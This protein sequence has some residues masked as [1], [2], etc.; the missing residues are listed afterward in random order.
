MNM[1]DHSL[2]AHRTMSIELDYLAKFNI[3]SKQTSNIELAALIDIKSKGSHGAMVQF[4]NS[5]YQ[6]PSARLENTS[7]CSA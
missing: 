5:I 3:N 7:P 1:N 6:N 2:P 4:A